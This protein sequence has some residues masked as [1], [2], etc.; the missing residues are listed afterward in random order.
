V[1]T[2]IWKLPIVGRRMVRKMN[3]DG[4]AQAD[5]AGHGGEQRR[6][7]GAGPE[8]GRYALA[9]GDAEQLIAL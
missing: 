7:H 6:V 4:N 5:L 2:S 9:S 3:V 1:R 8:A